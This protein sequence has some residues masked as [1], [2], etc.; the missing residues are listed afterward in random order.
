[1]NSR[2]PTGNGSLW[3]HPRH[4]DGPRYGSLWRHRGCSGARFMMFARGYVEGLCCTTDVFACSGTRAASAQVSRASAVDPFFGGRCYGVVVS[5]HLLIGRRGGQHAWLHCC[6]AQHAQDERGRRG[7]AADADSGQCTSPGSGRRLRRRAS[8]RSEAQRGCSSGAQRT[9]RLC[10]FAG[11][12]RARLPG[13]RRRGGAPSRKRGRPMAW[14]L[15]WGGG[16]LALGR[17][18]DAPRM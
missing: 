7:V 9:D 18:R 8:T 1:M 5:A 17:R 3:R 12:T 11:R 10:V 4:S 14:R 2:G 16:A 15:R 13:H 6:G